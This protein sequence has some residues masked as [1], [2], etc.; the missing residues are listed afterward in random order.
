MKLLTFRSLAP[1]LAFAAM[2]LP[3]APALAADPTE[4]KFG[5][6]DL[7]T[8]AGKATLDARIR[9]AAK[10]FCEAGQRTGTRLASNA[11]INDIRQQVLAEIDQ[12]QNRVGKGG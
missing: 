8:K 7:D 11:C 4:V 10:R 6:L 5:D 2:A 1:A 9:N 12:R 3:G